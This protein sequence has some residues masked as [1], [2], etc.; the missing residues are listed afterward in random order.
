MRVNSALYSAKRNI[1]PKQSNISNK[2]IADEI[3]VHN[4]KMKGGD[5]VN[6]NVVS[7]EPD[8]DSII[9]KAQAE[10]SIRQVKD[11]L[12]YSEKDGY[13]MKEQENTQI[14]ENVATAESI[15]MSNKKV[16]SIYDIP[17]SEIESICKQAYKACASIDKEGMT[18][19]ELYNRIES[20]FKEYL[21]EDF[22]DA[23]YVYGYTE[24][25]T[26]HMYF[27]MALHK[28]GVYSGDVNDNRHQVYKEAKGYAGMSEVEIHTAVRSKFPKDMTL[29]DCL[30]M[31]A[32]LA[33]LGLITTSYASVAKSNFFTTLYVNRG[34]QVTT[35]DSE[36]V[37]RK[38]YEYIL[39]M[40]ANYED[41]KTSIEAFRKSDGRLCF[42][43]N[44]AF[45]VDEM[46]G[47]LFSW[48]GGSIGGNDMLDKLIDILQEA[49]ENSGLFSFE[50]S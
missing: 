5:I 23:H 17:S 27:G 50:K 49:Q 44:V 48:F 39:D 38:M 18:K 12:T 43:H 36:M 13:I 1:I 42:E 45:S 40:P 32:E 6:K 24:E 30:L 28:L 16:N 21:G 19:A 33:N 2:K 47:E 3:L 31:E 29:R 15:P 26:A 20:T 35:P 11:S 8:L 34:T 41:I 25:A 14:N 4:K 22:I 7:T 9:L 37:S 46:L 10:N